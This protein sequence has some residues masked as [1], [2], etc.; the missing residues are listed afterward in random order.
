MI[1]TTDSA[2]EYITH[3]R[4]RVCVYAHSL[5]LHFLE[6]QRVGFVLLQSRFTYLQVTCNK[7][8][9]DNMYARRA[10]I[11]RDSFCNDVHYLLSITIFFHQ[12]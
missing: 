11:K 3:A 6:R 7:I 12:T 9:T 1:T 5:I 2:R 4:G 8:P 10:V